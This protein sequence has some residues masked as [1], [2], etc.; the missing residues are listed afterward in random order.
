MNINKQKSVW[1][2]FYFEWAWIETMLKSCTSKQKRQ[3]LIYCLMNFDVLLKIEFKNKL[4]ERFEYELEHNRT[5]CNQ[6]IS[7]FV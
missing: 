1:F 5:C 2:Y 3:N 6:A 4:A 7:L